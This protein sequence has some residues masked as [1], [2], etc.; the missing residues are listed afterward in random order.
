MVCVICHVIQCVYVVHRWVVLGVTI[1]H[2]VEL[3]LNLLTT[4]HRAFVIKSFVP[5]Y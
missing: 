4:V 5:E 1:Q 3:G 2:R